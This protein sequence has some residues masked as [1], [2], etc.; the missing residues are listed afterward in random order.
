MVSNSY[1]V[2]VSKMSQQITRDICADCDHPQ[3]NH[4]SGGVCSGSLTCMCPKY[5]PPFLFEFAQLVEREK[6]ERKTVERR[7]QFI[8]ERIPQSR[9]AG[10][11]TFAKIYREIWYGFKIRKSGTTFTTEEWKRMPHDDTINRAKRKCKQFH[12]E[13]KTYDPETIKQQ[14]AIFQAVLEWSV[15]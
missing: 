11:K 3:V 8:L 4:L 6:H 1:I 15:E 5:N 7:C 13:L 14:S 2:W 10:E 9:N 12:D